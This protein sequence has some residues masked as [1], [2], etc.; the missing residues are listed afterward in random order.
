MADPMVVSLGDWTAEW[1]AD[2]S[3]CMLAASWAGQMAASTV[4]MM[5]LQSVA[6][7]AGK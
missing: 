6:M 5:V 3:V 2:Y 4:A 7:M 1:W